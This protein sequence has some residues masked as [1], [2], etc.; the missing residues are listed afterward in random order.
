MELET[1]PRRPASRT[2]PILVFFESTRSG[3]CRRVDGYL[4]QVLQHRRNHETFKLYRVA[5]ETEPELLERF[6][7]S[8]VPTLLVIEDRR[9]MRRLEL[10]RSAKEVERFLAPWLL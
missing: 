10:P 1:Q 5:D 4:A 2:K 6:R 3:R 8:R 9:V 7:V